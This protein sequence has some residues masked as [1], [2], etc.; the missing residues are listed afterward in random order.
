MKNNNI[1]INKYESSK[2]F[3]NK[4]LNLN[5]DTNNLKNSD[6]QN[7]KHSLNKIRSITNILKEKNTIIDGMLLSTKKKKKILSQEISEKEGELINLE[8]EINIYYNKL[9]SEH[10][11]T[12]ENKGRILS[13]LKLIREE[14]TQK[15]Y[16]DYL[17]KKIIIEQKEEKLQQKLNL[18]SMEQLE[19]FNKELINNNNIDNYELIKKQYEDLKKTDIYNQIFNEI[20]ESLFNEKYN[21][22]QSMTSLY[23]NSK[24]KKKFNSKM[25]NSSN[26]FQLESERFYNK[27]KKGR[28]N[29]SMDSRYNF[30]NDD[31][32]ATQ[33]YLM[34]NEN[35]N[36]RNKS[37][38]E[39]NHN[40]N[41]NNHINKKKN[42]FNSKLFMSKHNL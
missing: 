28:N 31:L 38:F 35:N 27:K 12:D 5:L 19:L 26:Y 42:K 10:F 11:Q 37:F 8:N 2:S 17:N 7:L 41:N 30:E 29:Y 1:Q 33:K 9:F 14:L 24:S 16:A 23:D 21:N 25:L 39:Y 22:I 36:Y 20:K 32:T 4:Y 6:I 40:N 34:I 18:L 13:K 3:P 15:K